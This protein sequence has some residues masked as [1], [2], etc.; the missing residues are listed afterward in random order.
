M[1][2]TAR[3]GAGGAGG[4]ANAGGDGTG[5]TAVAQGGE[6]TGN[7]NAGEGNETSAGGSSTTGGT[8]GKGGNSSGGSSTNEG[9]APEIPTHVFV[10]D[11]G[12]C[13]CSTPGRQSSNGLAWL[14]ALALAGLVAERRRRRAA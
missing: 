2:G 12:G 5:G 14:G 1:R 4:E 10:R 8:N 9:G 7:S 3:W 6:P 11:P 13:A